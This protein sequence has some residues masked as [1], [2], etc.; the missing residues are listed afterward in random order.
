M[1][2]GVNTGSTIAASQIRTEFGAS[3]SNNQVSL[4]N[5]RISKDVN[6]LN[7]QPLDTG[8]PQSGAIAMSNFSQKSLNVIVNV[9]SGGTAYH[10]NAR[11]IYNNNAAGNTTV[12]GGFRNKK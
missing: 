11:S 12:L 7:D 1:T 4:G 5:Y 9:Y 6:A 10:Q 8:I 2:I 3:L